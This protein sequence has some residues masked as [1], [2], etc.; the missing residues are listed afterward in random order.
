MKLSVAGAFYFGIYI[1]IIC[2]T[3]ATRM[4]QGTVEYGPCAIVM[5]RSTEEMVF[6]GWGPSAVVQ[7]SADNVRLSGLATEASVGERRPASG[8]CELL[9]AACKDH[10]TILTSC[11]SSHLLS[12]CPLPICAHSRLVMV[13]VCW[14]SSASRQRRWMTSIVGGWRPSCLY[15]DLTE[16]LNT[17]CGQIV[18]FTL[19]F[20]RLS[21]SRLELS[22]HANAEHLTGQFVMVWVNGLHM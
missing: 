21:L 14:T 5:C 11:Q 15:I 1:L 2:V 13:I 18:K 10:V 17:T 16:V 3:F 7:T 12:P 6:I 20:T 4:L 19:G 8:A 22:V 9:H